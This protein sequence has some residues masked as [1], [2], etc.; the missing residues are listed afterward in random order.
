MN[1]VANVEPEEAN[2][3][4][5]ITHLEPPS[6]GGSFVVG[7]AYVGTLCYTNDLSVNGG[8]NN[9]KGFRTSINSWVYSDLGLSRVRWYNLNNKL[10]YNTFGNLTLGLYFTNPLLKMIYVLKAHQKFCSYFLL[11]FEV[12]YPQGKVMI[13][14]LYCTINYHSKIIL[15]LLLMKLAIIWIWDTI[16]IQARGVIGFAQLTDLS[17]Q[18]MVE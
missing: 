10:E 18:M 17:V 2:V 9:G 6:G 7:I 3:F 14:K 4:V 5:Y 11:V 16:F 8:T 1:H 12:V 13:A 15:R